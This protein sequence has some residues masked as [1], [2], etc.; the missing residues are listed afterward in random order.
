MTN[1]EVSFEGRRRVEAELRQRGA[2]SVTF[3]GKR[4]SLL[5]ATNPDHTRTVE[6]RVKTKRKGNWHTTINEAKAADKP[7]G[8]LQNAKNFWVFV[9]MGGKPR[10]WIVP[11]WWVRNNIHE[12]HQQYLAKH[13]WRRPVNNSSNHHSIEE[14]RLDNWLNKWEILDVF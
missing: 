9:D 14:S 11:D 8:A 10:F 3:I 13:D 6:I 12:K 5:Q 1:Q 2:G 4:K 7:E